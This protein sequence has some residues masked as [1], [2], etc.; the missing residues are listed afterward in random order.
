ME[1]GCFVSGG[2]TYTGFISQPLQE[3]LE[4]HLP[5]L[6]RNDYVLSKDGTKT[7]YKN[8]SLLGWYGTTRK[9]CNKKIWLF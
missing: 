3:I 8:I 9:V 2:E 4:R 1:V 7:P 5:K 6:G